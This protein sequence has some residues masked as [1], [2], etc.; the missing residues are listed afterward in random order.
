AG[1]AENLL[2]D[3][4]TEG[5]DEREQERGEQPGYGERQDDPEER[6]PLGRVQIV[7]GVQHPLVDPLDGHVQRQRGERQVVVGQAGHHRVPGGQHVEVLRQ[8]VRVLQAAQDD[9]L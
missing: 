1:T 5:R 2:V 4:V 9:A 6:L 8:Q 7:G 3:V